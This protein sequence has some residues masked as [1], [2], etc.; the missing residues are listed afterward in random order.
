MQ[1]NIFR[2]LEK[3]HLGM[4][5]WQ[6]VSE[7]MHSGSC[8]DHTTTFSDNLSSR[9]LLQSMNW[10]GSQKSLCLIIRNEGA[11][12]STYLDQVHSLVRTAYT[13]RIR[14]NLWVL[15]ITA[16]TMNIFLQRSVFWAGTII[17]NPV[18]TTARLYVFLKMQ[19]LRLS[20]NIIVA[21]FGDSRS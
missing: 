20:K 18:A 16:Q 9:H 8:P 14:A 17:C 13:D 12:E 3:I 21:W 5:L 7:R 2:K 15:T 10:M 6:Q 1:L 4:F 11:R 19:F